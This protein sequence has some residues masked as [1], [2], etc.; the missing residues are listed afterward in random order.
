MTGEVID[1][2]RFED[3]PLMAKLTVWGIAAHMGL[4]FG[5]PNQL[6]LTALA[7]GAPPPGKDS[8]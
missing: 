1:I 3:Y 4:L 6:V 5:L 8:P 2:L 7:V